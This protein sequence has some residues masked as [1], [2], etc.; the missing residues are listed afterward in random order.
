MGFEDEVVIEMIYN[1]MEEQQVD[2][3][4]IQINLTGF[5]EDNASV[6]TQELWNMLISAESSPMGIPAELIE[7]EKELIRQKKVPQ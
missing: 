1:M 7:L 2:P 5:M 4:V 6:F 3:R